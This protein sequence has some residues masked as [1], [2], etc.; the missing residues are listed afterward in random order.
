MERRKE[1][2]MNRIQWLNTAQ[3]LLDNARVNLI[4]S[5]SQRKGGLQ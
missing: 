3:T 1:K 4:L 5:A 2:I